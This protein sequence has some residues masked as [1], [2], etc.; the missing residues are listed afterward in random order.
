LKISSKKGDLIA[1][2]YL[3]EKSNEY[4]VK[5]FLAYGNHLD[6]TRAFCYDSE[7]EA[8]K[9]AYELVGRKI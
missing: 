3:S 9:K 7:E 2:V 4:L 6:K 1:E 5:F 8:V